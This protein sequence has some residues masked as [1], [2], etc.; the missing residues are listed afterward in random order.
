MTSER[1][2]A[3]RVRAPEVVNIADLREAAKRRLPDVVFGYLD[4]GAE[5]EIT[6]RENVR[7]FEAIAFRPR[8]CVPAAN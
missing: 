5:G 4:G 6:L 8:Q 1:R 7:A 3:R 2:L